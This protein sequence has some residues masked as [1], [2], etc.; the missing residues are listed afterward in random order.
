MMDKVE[1]MAI[2][3]KILRLR[4]AEIFYYFKD[5]KADYS[6]SDDWIYFDNINGKTIKISKTGIAETKEFFEGRNIKDKLI[7]IINHTQNIASNIFHTE[8]IYDVFINQ[9]QNI[10]YDI[11]TNGLK[12]EDKMN[13]RSFFKKNDM[14]LEI[15][16][17]ALGYLIIMKGVTNVE[18]IVT[19]YDAIVNEKIELLREMGFKDFKA[20]LNFI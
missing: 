4:D 18:D 13:I 11:L 9:S 8:V 17:V 14:I 10:N 7:E 5:K 1:V 12:Y 19:V 2:S 20:V 3:P 15:R 6:K 16:K